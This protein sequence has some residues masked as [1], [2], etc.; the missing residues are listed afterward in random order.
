MSNTKYQYRIE[1]T[2]ACSISRTSVMLQQLVYKT[3][4][5]CES[6]H[7]TLKKAM[8][9][10]QKQAND[11][12]QVIEVTDEIGVLAIPADE[13]LASRI[14]HC[15]TWAE[16]AEESAARQKKIDDILGKS[17]GRQEGAAP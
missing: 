4:E 8:A 2:V 5:A 11:R 13:I 15:E 14:C 6:A 3:K 16:F 9:D 10:T 12:D 17:E 7:A 1:L